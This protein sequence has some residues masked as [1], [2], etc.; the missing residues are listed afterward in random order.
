MCCKR[1]RTHAI[2]SVLVFLHL[3]PGESQAVAELLSAHSEH[4]SGYWLPTCLST[5]L[6]AFLTIA[7]SRFTSACGS[8]CAV[9]V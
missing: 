1:L 9:R 7:C 5:G 4:I 3:L 8:D 2:L 6:G